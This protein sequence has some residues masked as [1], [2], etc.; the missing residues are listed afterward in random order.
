MIILW[1][2]KQNADLTT[3]VLELEVEN[4]IRIQTNTNIN[5]NSDQSIEFL[6]K[7]GKLFSR[8]CLWRFSKF[9]I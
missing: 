1:R 2:Q 5:F 9:F 8:K 6:R 4:W 3:K 7:L